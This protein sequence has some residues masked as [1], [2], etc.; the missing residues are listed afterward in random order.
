[1]KKQTPP[2]YND[3]EVVKRIVD[4]LDKLDG[5]LDSV[6]KTLIVNTASLEEH[7]RRTALLEEQMIPVKRHIAMFEGVL[8]VVGGLSVIASL[9][10]SVLKVLGLIR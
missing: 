9:L 10:V 8:K 6:D 5:R 3:T 1:M 2:F 7:V 4:K